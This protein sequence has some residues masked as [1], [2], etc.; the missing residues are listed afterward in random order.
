MINVRR[1]GPVD[2]E[3]LVVLAR[4]FYDEDGFETTTADLR[5]NFG[6]LLP[7]D[8]AHVALA[9]L[10]NSL[11]GFALTTTA[12]VL[13]SGVVG[14]LQD[15]FVTLDGRGHGVGSALIED[16]ARWAKSRSAT[17]LEIVVAP[18]GG[19]V[20]QLLD[21][22]RARHFIDDGRRLIARKLA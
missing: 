13:E 11:C 22:Y 2:A 16:S 8:N 9:T 18:N 19:D 6:V 1:A 10:D 20:S 14:E 15:L 17:K 4:A 12:F 3:A 7:A 5:H 21:Y